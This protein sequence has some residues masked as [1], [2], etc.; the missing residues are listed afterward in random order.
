MGGTVHRNLPG[1]ANTFPQ[2]P[3]QRGR[4]L[5]LRTAKATGKA[6]WV[7]GLSLS[8]QTG[9]GAGLPGVGVWR[10]WGAGGP[11][12]LRFMGRT[13]TATLTDAIAHPGPARGGF[14]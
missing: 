9:L 11:T 2:S 1:L 5:P 7:R 14:H 4:P 3:L 13:L 8:I 10:G 12:H 6:R